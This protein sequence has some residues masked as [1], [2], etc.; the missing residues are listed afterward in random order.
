MNF[1]STRGRL[2]AAAVGAVV[3]GTLAIGASPASASA[4]SGYISGAG[5]IYDDFGDE[6]TLSSSS[7]AISS[8]TCFWQNVLYAEGA[9][10]NDEYRFAKSDIDGEFGSKTRY[11][12][13]NL[14]HRWGLTVDG[15]VGK[16]TMSKLDAK[17][18][19]L[20]DVDGGIWSGKLQYRGIAANGNTLATYHGKYHSFKMSRAEGSGH[21]HFEDL[22]TGSHQAA[23]YTRNDC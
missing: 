2:A 14:Q 7:H 1:R 6:G 15:I 17:R 3:A 5:T 18:V 23:S 19:Y 11:A 13:R 21:W 4:S 10:K 9:M 12:T 22:S 20:P 16:N 8:A